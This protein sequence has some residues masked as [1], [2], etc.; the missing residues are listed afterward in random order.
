MVETLGII[1]T[2]A[3]MAEIDRSTIYKW[4]EEDPKFKAKVTDV[5]EIALDFAESQMFKAIKDGEPLLIKFYLER[6]GK[7]RGYVRAT[8]LTGA[9]GEALFKAYNGVNPEDV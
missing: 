6:K 9:N 4:M 8:E 2:A 5:E 7:K 1:T 3:K